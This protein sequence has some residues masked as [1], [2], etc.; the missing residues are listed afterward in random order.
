MSH[1]SIAFMSSHIVEEVFYTGFMICSQQYRMREGYILCLPTALIQNHLDP[2]ILSPLLLPHD[3]R[4]WR[5]RD[6]SWHG[7]DQSSI[8]PRCGAVRDGN[9]APIPD[10][11]WG[12]PLLGDVIGELLIPAGSLVGGIPTPSGEA[13]AGTFPI[14]PSPFPVGVP[15]IQRNAFYSPLSPCAVHFI[16]LFGP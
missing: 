1:R 2:H 5:G 9:G 16:P 13:G 11:Q 12:F 3:V 6:C 7:G 10:P 15:E 14:S 4:R 8:V